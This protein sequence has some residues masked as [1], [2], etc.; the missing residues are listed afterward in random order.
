MPM[1]L[2]GYLQH[3]VNLQL[4]PYLGVCNL[5]N[6]CPQGYPFLIIQ[7]M[8]KQ[9]GRLTEHCKNEAMCAGVRCRHEELSYGN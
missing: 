5:N 9:G 8:Q 1:P 3:K 6:Y 2:Y 4:P 7:G